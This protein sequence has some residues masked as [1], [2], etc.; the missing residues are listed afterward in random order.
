MVDKFLSPKE[1]QDRIDRFNET[2]DWNVFNDVPPMQ[3]YAVLYPFKMEVH[4]I[5][6][7]KLKENETDRTSS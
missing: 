6:P 2:L 3:H 1:I 7:D 5:M 4:N